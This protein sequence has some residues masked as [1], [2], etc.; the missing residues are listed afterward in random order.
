MTMLL[1][2]LQKLCDLTYPHHI[3]TDEDFSALFNRLIKIHTTAP[4]IVMFI[5]ISPDRI[6]LS[7]ETADSVALSIHAPFSELRQSFM[8]R[9][10]T[11][12]SIILQGDASL[13][14]L[15]QRFVK[16]L[17]FDWQS[18][19]NDT[20][21][22]SLSYFLASQLSSGSRWLSKSSDKLA[23]SSGEYI[24]NESKIC[25]SKTELLM[26]YRH[27]DTLCESTSRLEKRI[28]SLKKVN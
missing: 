23:S 27:V 6:I 4:E 11:S 20:F 5:R 22:P 8:S 7:S 16:R 9:N 24:T 14:M 21:G 26:F 25:A 1:D 17:T 28:A 19:A 13:A 3:Y 2:S 12:K 18:L 10:Y 15:L